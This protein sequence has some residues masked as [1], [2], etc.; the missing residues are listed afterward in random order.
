M[1]SS[2]L[3]PKDIGQ[4]FGLHFA[5]VSRIIKS[6]ESSG[7]F[8]I[9]H[10]DHMPMT[11]ASFF[12]SKKPMHGIASA[13]SSRH[14]GAQPLHKGGHLPAVERAGAPTQVM[15]MRTGRFGC[16]KPHQCAAV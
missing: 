12:I 4:A 11:S 13:H 16:K 8:L 1:W 9:A 14:T 10:Y 6:L 15:R 7:I 5:S 2:P 3:S